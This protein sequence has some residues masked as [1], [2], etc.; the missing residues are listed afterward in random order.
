MA[1]AFVSPSLWALRACNLGV[2]PNATGTARAPAKSSLGV[3]FS[4]Q[5][6]GPDP[7]F[8]RMSWDFTKGASNG[9]T[10]LSPTIS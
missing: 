9:M 6:A 7:G 1:D 2:K 4:G 3:P 10:N 5:G 8:H